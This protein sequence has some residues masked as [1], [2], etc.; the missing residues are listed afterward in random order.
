MLNTAV[1]DVLAN[2]AEKL[3]KADDFNAALQELISET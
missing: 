1:A 2:Y 3:E